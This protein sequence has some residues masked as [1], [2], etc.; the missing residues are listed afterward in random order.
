[1]REPLVTRL[2]DLFHRAG[3]RELL[4]KPAARGLPRLGPR[5]P[6]GAVVVGR[7]LAKLLQ[8]GD[9]ARRIERHRRDSTTVILTQRWACHSVAPPA[10]PPSS[11][12]CSVC[13]GASGRGGAGSACVSP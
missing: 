13:S 5:E 6:L 8:L 4:A 2:V 3:L 1:E 12:S 9:R 11:S 7:E 10:G